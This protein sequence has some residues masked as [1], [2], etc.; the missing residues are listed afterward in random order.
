[1]GD[2]FIAETSILVGIYN[3][4]ILIGSLYIESIFI[5]PDEFHQQ[6]AIS[7]IAYLL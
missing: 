5:F 6:I 4:F 1:M 7:T 3:R 2:I